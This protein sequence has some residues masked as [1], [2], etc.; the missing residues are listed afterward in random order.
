MDGIRT[1]Y[2]EEGDEKHIIREQYVGDIRERCIS[3][4]NEG[5]VGQPDVKYAASI[6]LVVVEHYCKRHNITMGEWTKNRE[7]IKAMLN[8]PALSDFRI[9]K[10]R[11]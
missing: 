8:D 2:L 9:W 4:Q 7:H 5:L 11:V 6:P 10:G 3:M 1:A